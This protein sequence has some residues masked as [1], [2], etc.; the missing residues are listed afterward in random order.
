MVFWVG[1]ERNKETERLSIFSLDLHGHSEVWG[2]CV[3]LSPRTTHAD[4][5]P[6]EEEAEFPLRELVGSLMWLGTQ[7]GQ[8][9][10]NAARAVAG[11]CLQK[12]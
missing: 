5:D 4:L 6:D 12:R 1:Y 11:Y 2:R 10:S 9:I 8:G 3:P 7:V